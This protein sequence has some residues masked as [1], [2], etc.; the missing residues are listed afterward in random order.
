VPAQVAGIAALGDDDFINRSVTHNTEWRAWTIG[1]LSTNRLKIRPSAGN[2]VL[3]GFCGGGEAEACRQF[4]KSRGIL[5][6]QM[7]AYKLPEFLRISIGTG[8]EMTLACAVIKE[9]LEN[10]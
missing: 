1:E 6:R 5:V 9:Y 8:E 2:F 7:G 4:L 10:T 3:V